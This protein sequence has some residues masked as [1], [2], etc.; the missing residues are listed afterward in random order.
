[1]LFRSWE[2][3]SYDKYVMLDSV[4]AKINAAFATGSV[5]DTTT[6]GGWTSAK[7]Q[8]VASTTVIDVPFLKATGNPAQTRR[9]TFTPEPIPTEFALQ[10]NYPNPFN[11]TTTIQ[12][13]LANQSLVTL[14]IYNMLGQEV[15]TLLNREDMSAGTEELEFDASSLASGV[16]LYR[17]VAETVNDDGAVSQTYTQVKKMVLLK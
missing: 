3:V 1:M 5:S 15:A 17:V 10:Q 2:G 7:L 6:G 4:A 8:W 12:F 16:Y 13:D 11:P 9:G 14:K